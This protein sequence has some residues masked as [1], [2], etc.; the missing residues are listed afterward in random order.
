M[1][2]PL[3]I[4]KP[5]APGMR[6][7]G[8]HD[9]AERRTSR[10]PRGGERGCGSASHR[11]PQGDLGVARRDSQTQFRPDHGGAECRSS[12]IV[13]AVGTDPEVRYARDRIGSR[14]SFQIAAAV[15]WWAFAGFGFVFGVHTSSPLG[16][17]FFV[18]A[19]VAWC[20]LLGFFIARL[21]WSLTRE[22]L[23]GRLHGSGRFFLWVVV[24]RP[25]GGRRWREWLAWSAAVAGFGAAVASYAIAV[26]RS[27]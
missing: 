20:S 27:W 24:G 11:V 3:D 16:L 12:S 15:F 2:S 18:P 22:V 6:Q 25:N 1:S 10:S 13:P 26:A 9:G 5:S 17:L 23:W 14:V 7:E 21:G 4:L 8:G 19:A